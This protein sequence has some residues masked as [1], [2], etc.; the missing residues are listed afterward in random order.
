MDMKLGI[1]G[2]IHGNYPALKAVLDSAQDHDVEK[3]IITGDFVGY[4]FWPQEVLEAFDSWEISAVRGNHEEM[5]LK[6]ASNKVF[7]REITSRYGSGIRIAL[8]SIDKNRLEW[9]NSLPHPLDLICDNL[10]ILLCHGSPWDIN[11][12]IYPDAGEETFDMVVETGHDVVIL[13]H[14]HYPMIREFGNKLIINPGSTGQPR[15][16][17]PGAH[18]ALFDTDEMEG[19]NLVERY[20][21]DSVIKAAKRREPNLPYLWEV[22]EKV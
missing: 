6:A 3:L 13:G 7:L 16:H 22:L 2:D 10:K 15:N 1:L 19:R 14:T 8:E 17:V 11:R 4:Y 18:W 20:D 9:L 21:V 12:Y 5:M